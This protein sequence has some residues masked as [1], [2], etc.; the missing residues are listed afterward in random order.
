LRC[1]GHLKERIT[2][3]LWWDEA[4]LECVTLPGSKKVWHYN[5]IAL[6]ESWVES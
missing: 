4:V 2:P 3:Y 6:L 5:P 1:A